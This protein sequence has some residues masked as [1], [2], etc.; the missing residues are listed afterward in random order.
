M[1]PAPRVL[2]TRGPVDLR[3]RTDTPVY[4]AAAVRRATIS[5]DPVDPKQGAQLTALALAVADYLRS[6]RQLS[7]AGEAEGSFLAGDHAESIRRVAALTAPWAGGHIGP[8]TSGS[9]FDE[10]RE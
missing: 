2:A 9:Q 4:P 5:L 8:G 3:Q 7:E 6:A 1:V 10:I